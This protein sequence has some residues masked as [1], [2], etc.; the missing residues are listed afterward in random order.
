MSR[1]FPPHIHTPCAPQECSTH[2]PLGA[3]VFLELAMAL[4][5]TGRS[6]QAQDIY[7][8]LRRSKNREVRAQAKRCGCDERL[9]VSYRR[10]ARLVWWGGVVEVHHC[11][12]HVKGR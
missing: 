4:E 8:V 5:A 6:Y 3:V 7:K 9:L 11:G 1:H 10:E 2:G 12:R